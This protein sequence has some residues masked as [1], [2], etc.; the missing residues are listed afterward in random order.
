VSSG[1]LGPLGIIRIWC[2][3]LPLISQKRYGRQYISFTDHFFS[4]IL[5]LGRHWNTIVGSYH[6][7]AWW[8]C[9]STNQYNNFTRNEIWR[10]T[11]INE[12]PGSTGFYAV[13]GAM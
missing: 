4:P 6:G 1:L 2:L 13:C 9:N 11:S 7:E 12:F 10:L 8:K 3:M 5:G